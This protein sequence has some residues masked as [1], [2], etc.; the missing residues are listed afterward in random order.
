MQFQEHRTEAAC[1]APKPSGAP[2][3]KGI[4]SLIQLQKIS[5]HKR[6]HH[7]G[8]QTQAT[9]FL[10]QGAPWSP[11]KTEDLLCAFLEAGCPIPNC[12]SK[13]RLILAVPP[14]PY[15]KD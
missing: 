14:V 6:T 8:Q 7:Q 2:P 3:T 11:E 4:Y 13:F 12:C 10:V 1:P 15:T 9:N 5:P